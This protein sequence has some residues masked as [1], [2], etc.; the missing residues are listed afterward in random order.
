VI[1]LA[2]FVAAIVTED[3]QICSDKNVIIRRSKY[4]TDENTPDQLQNRRTAF[5]GVVGGF[6]SHSLPLFSLGRALEATRL[7]DRKRLGKPRTWPALIL[8]HP[9]QKL[10]PLGKPSDGDRPA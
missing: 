3:S 7:G 8:E 1:V 9:E 4:I 6:D 5:F 2:A 10:F